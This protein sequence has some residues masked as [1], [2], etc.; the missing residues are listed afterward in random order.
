MASCQEHDWQQWNTDAEMTKS[1]TIELV[2]VGGGSGGQKGLAAQVAG[3]DGVYYINT[4]VT[5]EM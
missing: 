1:G 2:S 3:F 5:D 4:T